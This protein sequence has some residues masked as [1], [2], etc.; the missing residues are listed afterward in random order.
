MIEIGRRCQGRIANLV[1]GSKKITST[2]LVIFFAFFTLFVSSK[3]NPYFLT[4]TAFQLIAVSALHIKNNIKGLKYLNNI[5][6][7]DKKADA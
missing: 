4:N 3:S 1:F 2:P 6:N 5:L 7:I